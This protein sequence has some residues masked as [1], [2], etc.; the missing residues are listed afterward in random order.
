MS[1][2]P[3]GEKAM[4]AAERQRRRR[5]R[6]WA[7]NPPGKPGRPRLSWMLDHPWDDPMD[8]RN[9]TNEIYGAIGKNLLGMLQEPHPYDL[10]RRYQRL[11]KKGIM[12]QFGRHGMW[13]S[14]KA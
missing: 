11:N 10:Y 14:P 1:R 5:E 12:E 6:L 3:I 2:N 13:L 9:L 8:R 4:T 7:E